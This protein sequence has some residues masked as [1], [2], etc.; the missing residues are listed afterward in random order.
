MDGGAML[1]YRRTL[2][3]SFLV[4]LLILSLVA[5]TGDGLHQEDLS[6]ASE[7]QVLQGFLINANEESS[8]LIIFVHG[9]G[10]LNYDAFG[11]YRHFWRVMAKHGIAVFSWDKPGVGG[12]EGNWL[13]QDMTQRATEVETALE[14]VL[15]RYPNRF[16]RVGVMGFS[17]AGWVLPK[18]DQEKFDFLVFAS[19]ALNWIEQGQYSSRLRL[20]AEG[21]PQAAIDEEL[22]K[23]LSSMDQLFGSDVSYLQYINRSREKAAMSED[24]FHFVQL[25]WQEDAREELNSIQLPVLVVHGEED[26]NVDGPRN[27]AE[28]RQIFDDMKR[29]H[30]KIVLIP[31]ATHQL[32]SSEIFNTPNPGL[33]EL[34]LLEIFGESAYPCGVLDLI[35]KW[36]NALP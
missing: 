14:A 7:G 23:E 27:S 26:L 18:L 24:R 9:D 35:P 25:N 13:D 4:L 29:A 17:Q 8:T 16:Q 19:T 20:E 12:S 33:W 30:Q 5:V 22:S 6:F 32:S 2:L 1:K 31:E 36:I 10:D 15:A 28:Y 11:F 34:V 3:G 21:L